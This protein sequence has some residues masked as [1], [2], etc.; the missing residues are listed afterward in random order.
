MKEVI[1]LDIDSFYS[2]I[3][4]DKPVFVDFWAEWCAPCKVAEPIIHKLAE[5]YQKKMIF[6]RLNVDK[7]PELAR[8]HEVMSI[9]TFI[10]FYKGREIQRLIGALPMHVIDSEIQKTLKMIGQL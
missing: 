4:G 1:E 3:E 2:I 6:C 5:K 9:P 7:Y 8:V 10:I